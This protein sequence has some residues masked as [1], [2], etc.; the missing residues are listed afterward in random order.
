MDQSMLQ[1]QMLRAV[2]APIQPHVLANRFLIIIAD[3]IHVDGKE[4]TEIQ[5]GKY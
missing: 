3:C 1:A 4:A 5:D 2:P